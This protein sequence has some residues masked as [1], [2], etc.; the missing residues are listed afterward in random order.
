MKKI[1]T[2]KAP[3]PAGH[4]SQAIVHNGLVYVAG[5]LPINPV[6]GEK[7]LGSIEE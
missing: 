6:T 5:Q 1:T 4:Y 2:Q 3:A 7:L